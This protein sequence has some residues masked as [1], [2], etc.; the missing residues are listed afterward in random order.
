[1][2]DECAVM[3]Y[4]VFEE[5]SKVKFCKICGPDAIPH[6]LLKDLVDVLDALI[7]AVI[8]TS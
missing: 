3:E 1:L 4:E 8:S 5:I 7:T 2:P 6:R